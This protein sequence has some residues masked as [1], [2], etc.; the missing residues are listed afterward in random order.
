MDKIISATD[1][2]NHPQLSFSKL[3][4]AFSERYSFSVISVNLVME[5]SI[6]AVGSWYQAQVYVIGFFNIAPISAPLVAFILYG[7]FNKGVLSPEVI[8]PSLVW[9][10]LLNLTLLLLCSRL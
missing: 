4:T 9:F 6:F 2:R 5:L 7:S 8:F 10:G 3:D 1:R